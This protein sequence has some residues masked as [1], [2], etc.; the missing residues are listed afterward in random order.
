MPCLWD[1]EL[2]DR[3]RSVYVEHII[4]LVEAQFS[5]LNAKIARD[6]LPI[7][8]FVRATVEHQDYRD[9]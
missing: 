4:R 5:L 3:I 8:A 2:R 6:F 9:V 7:E 1:G